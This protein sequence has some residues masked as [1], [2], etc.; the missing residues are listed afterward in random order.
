MV[1]PHAS[2][3]S[4]APLEAEEVLDAEA[5]EAQRKRRIWT[6][7][8]IVASILLL[9][10]G[11]G[12]YWTLQC[13]SPETYDVT[14]IALKET[15]LTDPKKLPLGART[16]AVLIHNMDYLLHKPGGYLSN[17]VTPPSIFLDNM[18]NWE[19]GVVVASR[20]LAT[21]LRNHLSRAQSQSQE[22]KDL[23]VGE[24]YYYF[25]TDSWILPATENQYQ[26]GI[27]AFRRYLAR[28]REGKAPFYPRADN[29][30]QYVMILEKRLG[31]YTQRLSASS[32]VHQETALIVRG[33]P[34]TAFKP[35]ERTPWLLVDDNFYE[36]RGYAWALLHV[37]EAIENDFHNILKMKAAET[38]VHQIIRELEATQAPILSPV[39]LNGSGFGIFANYSL[40]LATYIAHANAALIDLR[41]LL[42]I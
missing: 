11:L 29:L 13:Y 4:E 26:K 31:S 2:T 3:E 20:D 14:E 34:S 23:A 10:T 19:F 21:A 33:K 5:E 8:G 40:T 17:D 25:E 16:T 39:V 32:S 35:M 38:P 37:M 41:D 28:L 9:F 27:D 36:A 24:P 1:S 22:D 12:W 6:L 42:S 30:T 15:G 18:P 7:V